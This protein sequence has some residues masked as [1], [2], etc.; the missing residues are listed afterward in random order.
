MSA[1]GDQIRAVPQTLPARVASAAAPAIEAKARAKAPVRSG[2]L[3]ASIT[4]RVAGDSVVVASDVPY[5][6]FVD[7]AIEGDYSAELDAAVRG[8]Q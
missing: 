6:R 7:N 1:L 8:V 5:A 2:R 3:R 4:A